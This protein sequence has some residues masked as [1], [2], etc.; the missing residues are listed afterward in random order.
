VRRCTH[1]KSGKPYA[2]KFIRKRR[3]GGRKGAK[4]E[5]IVKE[6]NVLRCIDHPNVISLHEVYDTRQEVILVLEL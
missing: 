5:D 6:I 1:R 3:G 2:A 4:M